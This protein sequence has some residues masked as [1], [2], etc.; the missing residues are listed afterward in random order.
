MSPPYACGHPM[1]SNPDFDVVVFAGGSSG[2]VYAVGGSTADKKAKILGTHAVG[3]PV[4]AR[5]TANSGYNSKTSTTGCNYLYVA[6]EAGQLMYLEVDSFVKG[7]ADPKFKLAGAW[8]LGGGVFSAI[9]AQ[10][11]G[12]CNTEMCGTHCPLQHC[13]PAN[14]KPY[15]RKPPD[16]WHEIVY[17]TAIDDI[18]GYV[19][20]HNL[21]RVETAVYFY[22]C[23]NKD[24]IECD[25]LGAGVRTFS[26]YAHNRS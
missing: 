23:G 25:S 18:G 6:D 14:T 9:T 1:T 22:Q 24:P 8:T 19:L 15:L 13:A 17:A 2:K 5:P 3:A 16:G 11:K 20:S 10:D 26:Q 4:F 7:T 21:S 12:Q